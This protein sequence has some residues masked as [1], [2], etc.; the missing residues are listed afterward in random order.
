MTA[1]AET[2]PART[3]P[4]MPRG[5]RKDDADASEPHGDSRKVRKPTAALFA[6]IDLTLQQVFVAEVEKV[7]PKTSAQAVVEMLIEAWLVERGVW[8]VQ[9][10]N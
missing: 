7:R 4:G 10:G 2:M 9:G 8:P 1:V 5:K 3:I 6:R